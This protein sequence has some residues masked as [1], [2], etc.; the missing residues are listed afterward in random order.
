MLIEGDTTPAVCVTLIDVMA[1][2]DREV[3]VS[4]TIMNGSAT[5]GMFQLYI[6]CYTSHAWY[7]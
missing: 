4:V 3:T 5:E 7:V 6:G 2:L 1:G